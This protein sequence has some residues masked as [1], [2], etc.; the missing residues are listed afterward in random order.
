MTE[1]EAYEAWF[2]GEQGK[3]YDEAYTFAEAA[4][5]AALAWLRS[6]GEP[7]AW[8]VVTRE[9]VTRCIL[10]R[11]PLRE[12]FDLGET[13]VPLFL[14]PQPAWRKVDDEIES[15]VGIRWVS[16]TGIHGRPTAHDVREYLERRGES[17]KCGCD[18]CTAP[19]P[20][21]PDGWQ[22]I[23]TAPKDELIL[24]GPTKRMGVC[25]AMNHSRDGWCTETPSEWV[26]IY[27]PTCW[28][29]IPAAPEP[30][31]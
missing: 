1:Q 4:W 17:A 14:A 29:P 3:P 10:E 13:F 20:A 15:G 28:M 2:R 25:A 23:E 12:Q 27:A 6:Q 7:V 30:I 24:V 16:D 11:E 31:K 8:R 21:I 5:H 22:P 18:K 9:G 26:T 19:Q